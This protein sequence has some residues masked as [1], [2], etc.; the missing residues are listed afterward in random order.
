MGHG[1]I[2]RHPLSVNS[3]LMPRHVTLMLPSRRARSPGIYK[4]P[5]R[6]YFAPVATFSTAE[7][8]MGTSTVISGGR[9]SNLQTGKSNQQ[10][11]FP[12]CWSRMR[13]NQKRPEYLP[14]C[15]AL[16]SRSPDFSTRAILILVTSLALIP[17]RSLTCMPMA[18]CGRV[19]GPPAGE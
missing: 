8:M 3:V 18:V 2:H 11:S 4:C 9:C 12:I 14:S 13:D 16:F 10:A 17:R 1:L 6:P 7:G 19:Y 15:H 5:P